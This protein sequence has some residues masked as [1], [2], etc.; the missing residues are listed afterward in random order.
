M[1]EQVKRVRL[2]SA[3]LA[4]LA[5]ALVLLAPAA[6]AHDELVS[7]SP[8]DGSS[9]TAPGQVV[10]RFTDDLLAIG[11]RVRIEGPRPAA[12][13]S[14]QANG[15]T[16][17]ASLDPNL[18][19]GAYRVTWR[20]VSADGHPLSGAFAFTLTRPATASP[21]P[22]SE[23]TAPRT[24]AAAAP[25]VPDQAGTSGRLVLLLAAVGALAAGLGVAAQRTRSH[26]RG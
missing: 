3:V 14:A 12:N 22:T 1:R 4:T 15:P 24:T 9:V 11:N 19:A 17:T 16:L 18:P 23:P 2:A 6:S 21:V 25:P 26:D 7:T 13:L 8:Q 5:I 10:L 20:A